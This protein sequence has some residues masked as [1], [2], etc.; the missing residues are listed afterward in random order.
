MIDKL[1]LQKDIS[2]E[3]MARESQAFSMSLVHISRARDWTSSS[4]LNIRRLESVLELLMFEDITGAE[5]MENMDRE[6]SDPKGILAPKVVMRP[7][8]LSL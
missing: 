6:E 2:P 4:P 3:E 7:T 5:V 1:R 8:M